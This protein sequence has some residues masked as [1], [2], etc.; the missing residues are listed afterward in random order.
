MQ[1]QRI[2]FDAAYKFTLWYS[3]LCEAQRDR[4]KSVEQARHGSHV[5]DVASVLVRASLPRR[6]YKS[7]CLAGVCDRDSLTHKAVHF[8]RPEVHIT[9]GERDDVYHCLAHSTA[10]IGRS[11]DLCVKNYCSAAPLSGDC[12][13]GLRCIIQ[14]LQLR[15]LTFSGITSLHDAQQVVNTLSAA[16]RCGLRWLTRLSIGGIP[17]Y[18]DLE[19]LLYSLGETDAITELRLEE[20]GIENV[21]GLGHYLKSSKKLQKLSL[22]GNQGICGD[23]KSLAVAVSLCSSLQSF[24]AGLCRLNDTHLSEFLLGLDNFLK[25]SCFSLDMSSN[26][27]TKTCFLCF[28]EAP[29]AFRREVTQ[30]DISG[31]NFNGA[32][33]GAAAMLLELP[34]LR[35]VVFDRCDIGSRDVQRL[36]RVFTRKDRT[37]SCLS[38]RGSALTLNDMKRLVMT[39]FAE[40]SRLCIGGNNIGGGIQKLCLNIVLPFLCELDLSLCDIGDT[41]VLQLA[42]SIEKAQPVPLRSLRLDNNGIGGEG[43]RG[44]GGL[45]FLGRALRSSYSPCLEVLSLAHNKLSLKPLLTLVEQVSSTLR[46]LCISYTPIASDSCEMADL[47]GRIMRRQKGSHAF[48]ELDVWALRSTDFDSSCGSEA[49]SWLERQRA[50]RVIMEARV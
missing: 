38:F 47:V 29:L 4:A 19:P 15:S 50:V 18:A 48:D 40:R 8:G 34:A 22:R 10:C 36:V 32:G 49:T 23:M 27:L 33:D 1:K 39:T 11:V 20:C 14:H 6:A 30:L 31:H 17:L 13:G 44:R 25:R 41:G 26:V 3:L 43:V 9:H 45:Q 42:N 21:D 2:T 28:V 5:R 16:V 12:Y 37:W 35:G 7:C 24:D 46:E